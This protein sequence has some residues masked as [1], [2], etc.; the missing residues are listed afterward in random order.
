M[1]IEETL[2]EYAFQNVGQ[3]RAIAKELGYSEEYN[4][5]ELLSRR[6]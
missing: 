3:F 6:A 2:K 1:R 4:K 5:G